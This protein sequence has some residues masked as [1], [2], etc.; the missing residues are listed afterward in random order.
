MKKKHFFALVPVC[1]HAGGVG[2]C[3]MVQ[4]LQMWDFIC[5]NG[6]TENRVIE[7]VDQQYE[8]FEYPVCIQN[9]CYMPPTSPGYSTKFTEDSIKNYS[10][11]NGEKWK[12]MYKKDSSNLIQII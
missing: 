11:P 10:Y 4:H 5:L 3:E 8:H 9:A 6:S 7:Y 12:N 2:L 1:P